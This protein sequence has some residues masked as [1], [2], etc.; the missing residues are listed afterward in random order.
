ML[1]Y[2]VKNLVSSLS[3]AFL[4]AGTVGEFETWPPICNNFFFTLT[5]VKLSVRNSACCC[6][7]GR[8]TALCA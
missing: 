4:P 6:C 5:V 3:S 1:K 8:H 7:A 2:V